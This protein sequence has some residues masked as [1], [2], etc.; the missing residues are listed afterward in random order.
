[1]HRLFHAA[2]VGADRGFEIDRQYRPAG[3]VTSRTAAGAIV[4]AVLSAAAAAAH[5]PRRRSAV[6]TGFAL[7][8]AGRQIVAGAR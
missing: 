1:V 8:D 7:S 5:R 2:D 4:T 3:I 6:A